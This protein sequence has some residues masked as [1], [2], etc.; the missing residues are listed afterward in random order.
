MSKLGH[1]IAELVLQVKTGV[2]ISN[3]FN[4]LSITYIYR[5]FISKTTYSLTKIT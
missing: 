3:T 2:F 5:I 4:I 1:E